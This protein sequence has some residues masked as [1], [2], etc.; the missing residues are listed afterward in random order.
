LE[1][2]QAM[3]DLKPVI[4][5][6]QKTSTT[7]HRHLR[8]KNILTLILA[9]VLLH[10]LGLFLF[11]KFQPNQSSSEQELASKPIDFV[12]VPPPEKKPAS[13]KTPDNSD[14]SI[15]KKAAKVSPANPPPKQSE[16][17]SAAIPTPP[18][19]STAPPQSEVK[20]N[21]KESLPE[22]LVKDPPILSGSDK[23]QVAA[24]KPKPE[25]KSQLEPAIAKPFPQPLKPEPIATSLPPAKPS[26]LIPGNIPGST[27]GKSPANSAEGAGTIPN[28]SAASLLGGDLKKTYG[29][30]KTDAFFSPEAL[31]Y[32]AVL[33]PEQLKALQGFDLEGYQKRLYDKV[34]R[35]WQPS[36][37]QKY[38]TWLTF[39]IEK[40]GQI[41]QLKVVE[42]SGSKDFDQLAL[43]A[44]QNAV[45]LE[46]L[47]ADFPLEHLEFKYQFYL[48]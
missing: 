30:N 5:N 35:N 24:S 11:S 9:S 12:A 6:R 22:S 17:T 31:A 3:V 16:A 28:D 32:E 48:Y 40:N 13:K 21:V 44:V 7:D 41:S 47:P 10:G 43:T 4:R 19:Q 20:P 15:A 36:F 26:K 1:G 42:S 34:K 29:D 37:S 46:S 8:P 18:P 45:P 25:S 33:D 14:N 27:P 39:N 38:T 2:I 23:N